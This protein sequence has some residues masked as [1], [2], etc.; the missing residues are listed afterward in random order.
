MPG[1]LGNIPTIGDQKTLLPNM[2]GSYGNM[3][4]L[5]EEKILDSLYLTIGNSDSLGLG[6]WLESGHLSA[7]LVRE[8]PHIIADSGEQKVSGQS[9][10]RK[11]ERDR[12]KDIDSSDDES[13][14]QEYSRWSDRTR[15]KSKS[16]Q[17]PKMPLFS[18]SGKQACLLLLYLLLFEEEILDSLYLTIGNSD[19]LGLG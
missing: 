14:D 16:P 8:A 2:H 19:S 17:P 5:F 4:P 6:Y 9:R 13:F 1:Q 11:R 15:A 3:L 10:G 12:R 18:G 7:P